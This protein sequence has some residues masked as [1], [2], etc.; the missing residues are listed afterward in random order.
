M[1]GTCAEASA[2]D[3]PTSLADEP[4]FLIASTPPLSAI[5]KY[6]LFTCLGRNAIL[7]PVF[8]APPDELL[9]EVDAEAGALFA[10]LLLF[11][12]EPQAAKP[13]EATAAHVTTTSDRR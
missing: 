4:S 10:S 6:G 13:T 1:Y 11:L 8:V 3:G 7:S 9:L 12:V 5:V 2:V